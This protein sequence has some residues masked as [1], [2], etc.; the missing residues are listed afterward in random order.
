MLKE[1]INLLNN[2][3]VRRRQQFYLKIHQLAIKNKVKT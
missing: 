3:Q 2:N 1:I